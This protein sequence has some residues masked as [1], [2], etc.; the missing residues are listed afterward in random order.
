MSVTR[1]LDESYK[2]IR[3]TVKEKELTL[4]NTDNGESAPS[5]E[6]AIEMQSGSQ[7]KSKSIYLHKVNHK[8]LDFFASITND[9]K[10]EVFF[11]K[12]NVTQLLPDDLGSH[13]INFFRLYK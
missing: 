13:L 5:N 11:S 12:S 7:N 2:C 9:Y 4:V 6:V 1:K 8:T 3:I 10:V